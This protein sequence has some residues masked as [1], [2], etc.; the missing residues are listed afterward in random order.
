MKKLC[1]FLLMVA[2]LSISARAQSL[3]QAQPVKVIVPYQ[4]TCSSATIGATPVEM[5]GNTTAANTSAS[6][7]TIK[8]ENI[9]QTN[10]VYCSQLA[11]VASSGNSIGDL[12]AAYS[13]TGAWP[14]QT[15]IINA[16]QP[17]YCVAAGANTSVMVCKQK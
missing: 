13:G 9:S 1:L 15:W 11:T 12:V 10:A 6:I 17:W 2:G 3:T 5:T 8:V 14:S 7:Y 16:F 4:T